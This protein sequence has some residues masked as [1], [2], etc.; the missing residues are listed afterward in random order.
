MWLNRS[1][2]SF[3]AQGHLTLYIVWL[4]F[5]GFWIC[6]VV[7]HMWVFSPPAAKPRVGVVDQRAPPALSVW[8]I[9]PLTPWL[10]PDWLGWPYL[11]SS[12]LHWDSH[13]SLP[14]IEGAC[15]KVVSLW[16][17]FPS[18]I[19]VLLDALSLTSS[20]KLNVRCPVVFVFQEENCWTASASTPFINLRL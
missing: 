12:Q 4:S 16:E 10:G 8:D 9:L 3:S 7:S 15:D 14:G 13:T 6:V 17:D 19:F 1:Y 5:F 11:H 18:Y 20:Y 2:C